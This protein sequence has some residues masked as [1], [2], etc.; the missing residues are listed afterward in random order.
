MPYKTGN[1]QGSLQNENVEPFFENSQSQNN[2][3]KEVTPEIKF[4]VSL[5]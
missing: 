5:V 3:N 1:F 2:V 4:G